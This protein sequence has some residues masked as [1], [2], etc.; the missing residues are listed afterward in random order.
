MAFPAVVLQTCD[1]LRLIDRRSSIP[2]SVGS[3]SVVEILE[4]RQFLFEISRRPEQ[5]PVE[6]LPSKR[7]DQPFDERMGQG[8]VRHGLDPGHLQHAE[9]GEPLMEENRGSLSEL[10]RFGTEPPRIARLNIRQR[11]WAMRGQPQFGFRRLIATMASINSLEGPLGPVRRRFAENSR[12]YF[13]LR[14][15]RW[16]SRI[17][18]GFNTMAERISRDERNSR[19]HR[20]VRIRS[21]ALRFGDRCRERFRISSWCLIRRDSATTEPRPPGPRSRRSVVTR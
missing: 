8:H 1:I 13:Q 9:V 20:P 16:N 6:G 2:R 15:A 14:S 3:V 5:D 17:G 12:R 10:R 18:A 11:A 7:A 4:G 19:A 21:E